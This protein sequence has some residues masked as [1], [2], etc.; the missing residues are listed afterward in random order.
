MRPI[1]AIS[2]ICLC[3]GACAADRGDYPSLRP[4]AVES[5]ADDAAGSDAASLEPVVK[6]EAL[7]RQVAALADQVRSA[8]NAFDEAMRR[9]RPAVL[10]ARGA[11]NG[12]GAWIAGQ[13]ALATLDARRGALL[14]PLAD[15]EQLAIDRAGAGQQPYPA[16]TVAI[17]EAR[18]ADSAAAAQLAEIDAM[19]EPADGG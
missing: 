2:A 1:P 18:Q 16:L 15:L 17:D 6:D 11:E 10:A 9:E 7:D 14:W 4:R 19:L 8:A 13:A 12:S 3:L 5:A